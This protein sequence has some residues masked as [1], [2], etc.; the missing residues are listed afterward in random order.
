MVYK[1]SD[2]S[3]GK[4]NQEGHLKQF[5]K[6]DWQKTIGMKIISKD[7]SDMDKII[8]DPDKDYNTSYLIDIEYG[9]H[10]RF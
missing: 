9:D 6:V 5:D 3:F 10:E 4:E 7:N 2:S 1:G 8:A